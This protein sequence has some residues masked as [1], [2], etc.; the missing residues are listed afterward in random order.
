MARKRDLASKLSGEAPPTGRP[1]WMETINPQVGQVPV[2]PP[3]P[4]E[5]VRK[6]RNRI[7]R[8]T[9]LLSGDLIERIEALA[10]Q[11]RVGINELVRFLLAEAI[12][13]VEAGDLTIP[14]RP[15]KRRIAR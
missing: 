3:P 8:K 2:T 1:G 5:P 11:E 6:P 7:R 13:Q 12:T 4:A 15:A 9:Y 14:T 10:D